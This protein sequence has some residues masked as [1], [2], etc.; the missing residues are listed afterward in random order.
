[1]PEP[2]QPFNRLHLFL[3]ILFLGVT[4]PFLTY[5]RLNNG[6]H[7]FLFHFGA[8]VGFAF[9]LWLAIGFTWPD[10]DEEGG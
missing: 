7:S 9:L 3:I 1:M 4:T 2:N 6:H 10:D 5:F 8:C